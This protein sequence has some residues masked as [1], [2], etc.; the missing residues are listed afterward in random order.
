VDHRCVRSDASAFTAIYFVT[1]GEHGHKFHFY[2]RGSAVSRIAPAEV[3]TAQIA[4][5]P[6][7]H[8]S[9]IS[10]AISNSAGDGL[11]DAARDAAAAAALA[12]QGYGAVAPIPRAAAVR[13]ALEAQR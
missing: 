12:T 13:A 9:G 7:L 4:V 11:R 3:P 1:H 10:L 8:L 5:A 6:V 2:R